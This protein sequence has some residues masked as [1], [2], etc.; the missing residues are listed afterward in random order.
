MFYGLIFKVNS[1]LEMTSLEFGLENNPNV[2]RE[3]FEEFSLYLD[4]LM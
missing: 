2:S 1:T 3:T 4:I